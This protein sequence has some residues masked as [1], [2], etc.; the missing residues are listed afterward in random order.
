MSTV[1][2]KFEP[3]FDWT[4]RC[5]LRR[6]LHQSAVE[7]RDPPA[8]TSRSGSAGLAFASDMQRPRGAAA[9]ALRWLE[10]PLMELV[11][12]RHRQRGGRPGGRDAVEPPLQGTCLRPIAGAPAPACREA[13]WFLSRSL[14]PHRTS[15]RPAS[16]G[17]SVPTKYMMTEKPRPPVPLIRSRPRLARRGRRLRG[18]G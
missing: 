5:S 13:V 4:E 7:L 12:H 2:G 10:A 8:S 6:P 18:A 3:W 11:R 14:S 16:W 1:A 17:L 15:R 9:E